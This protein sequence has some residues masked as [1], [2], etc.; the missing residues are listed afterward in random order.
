LKNVDAF[1]LLV[2]APRPVLGG[3]QEEIL[4]SVP[5][6]PLPCLKL[7][8]MVANGQKAKKKKKKEKKK[9]ERERT[10]DRVVDS[11]LQMGRDPIVTLG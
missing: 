8:S 5:P 9:R 10:G 7:F 1:D 6:A 3:D 4:A 2:L 11:Q